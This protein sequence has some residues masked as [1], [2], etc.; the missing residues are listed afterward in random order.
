MSH[1]KRPT[2]ASPQDLTTLQSIDGPA[3]SS[4]DSP[5]LIGSSNVKESGST[6]ASQPQPLDTSEDYSPS[7]VGELLPT[8]AS[9]TPSH[10][11][12]CGCQSNLLIIDWYYALDRR[13]SLLTVYVYQCQDR[14]ACAD[15]LAEQYAIIKDSELLDIHRNGRKFKH[16]QKSSKWDAHNGYKGK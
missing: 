11:R 10:C 1:R 4:G 13:G 2:D 6:S 5:P 3:I 8:P 16:Y 12:R 9:S 15:R 7:L 14:R